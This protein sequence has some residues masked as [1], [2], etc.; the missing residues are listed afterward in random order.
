MGNR[1]AGC[2]W[3]G[4]P[5]GGGAAVRMAGR[6]RG[7]GRIVRRRSSGQGGFVLSRISRDAKKLS[8]ATEHRRD[9]RVERA[10]EFDLPRP[11]T[12]GTDPLSCRTE[13]RSALSEADGAVPRPGRLAQDRRDAVVRRDVAGAVVGPDFRFGGGAEMRC[14]RSLDRLGF[15]PAIGPAPVDRQHQS[16]FDSARGTLAE[17]RFVGAFAAGE[18][19]RRG[20]A[21]ALRTS[22]AAARDVCRSTALPWAGSGPFLR[23]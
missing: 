8:A 14:A 23:G 1:V 13:R 22:A 3:S 4:D 9:R 2:G 10:H 17:R 5:K 18:A 16:F 20:L 21:A 19:D 7:R 6:S 12:L 11:S 15:P